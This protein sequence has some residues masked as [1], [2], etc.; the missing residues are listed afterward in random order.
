VTATSTPLLHPELSSSR[1]QILLD[2]DE[3]NYVAGS[4]S[5]GGSSVDID[6]S[7]WMKGVED[8][9]LCSVNAL[10]TWLPKAQ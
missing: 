4:N 1:K 2:V 8:E 9:L 7:F 5:S 6:S 10:I 3:R